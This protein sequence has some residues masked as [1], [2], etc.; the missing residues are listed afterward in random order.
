VSLNSPKN[1]ISDCVSALSIS[2]HEPIT[3]RILKCMCLAWVVAHE[4]D[5][6]QSISSLERMEEE[7]EERKALQ[8]ELLIK[9]AGSLLPAALF[10]GPD[11][12]TDRE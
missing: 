9:A 1:E 10:F 4:G 7:L 8:R 6:S 3:K 2:V 12:P 5:L 11:S